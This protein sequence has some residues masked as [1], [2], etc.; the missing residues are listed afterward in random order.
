MEFYMQKISIN[1]FRVGV[2]AVCCLI[3][4]SLLLCSER[5]P[6]AEK[7]KS[8][9]LKSLDGTKKTLQ[10]FSNKATLVGFYY[11]TCAYCNL[12][13]PEVVKIYEKYKDQ[14]LSI[15]IINVKQEEVKLIAGWQGKYHF[16]IPV[17]I[18]ASQ[19]SLMDDYDLTITPTHILLGNKGE[20]LLR[21]NGY[22]R[23]D[24]NTIEAKIAEALKIALDP[25]IKEKPQAQ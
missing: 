13:I 19:D 24:E 6:A 14:G 22:N 15:V 25:A 9:K 16:T 1:K 2:L 21:Q 17:L 18:G 20:V 12:A 10:D 3:L 7:F 11:P 8:F 4:S 23:G 5:A